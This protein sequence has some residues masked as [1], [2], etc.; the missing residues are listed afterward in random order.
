MFSILNNLT[1]FDCNA[2]VLVVAILKDEA[3]DFAGFLF[4]GS[5]ELAKH[6]RIAFAPDHF[7]QNMFTDNGGGFIKVFQMGDE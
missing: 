4:F 7:R 1:A 2:W 6:H 5:G 3:L